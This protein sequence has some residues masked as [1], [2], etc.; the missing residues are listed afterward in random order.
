MA[1]RYLVTGI[2]VV[3]IMGL[4]VI[5]CVVYQDNEARGRDSR[6]HAALDAVLRTSGYLVA[7]RGLDRPQDE[8]SIGAYVYLMMYGA[9]EEAAALCALVAATALYDGERPEQVRVEYGPTDDDAV[10]C[11]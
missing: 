4:L 1:L 2:V 5:G 3:L 7:V 6:A 11:D 9:R 10:K 8:D